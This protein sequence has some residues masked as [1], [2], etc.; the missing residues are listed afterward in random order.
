MASRHDEAVQQV[1]AKTRLQAAGHQRQGRIRDAGTAGAVLWTSHISTRS[2]Y[3]LVAAGDMAKRIAPAGDSILTAA[4]PV[5]DACAEIQ[6]QAQ[7]TA[8]LA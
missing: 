1:P 6:H 8:S 4:K 7:R 3:G 5:I 2:V